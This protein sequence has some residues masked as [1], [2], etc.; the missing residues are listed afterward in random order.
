[1]GAGATILIAD[2]AD[3]LRAARIALEQKPPS[4][5]FTFPKQ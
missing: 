3:V 5:E 1:M 2:D 4:G